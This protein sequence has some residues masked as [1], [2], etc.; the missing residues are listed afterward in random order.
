MTGTG[1][2]GQE[3]REKLYE[4]VRKD[5][6]FDQ[7]AREALELGRRYLGLENGH[8]T[9]IDQV[10]D[11]WEIVASTDP[12]H[13]QFPPGLELG[14]G[15]T[16]CR[17]VVEDKT[18]VALHDAP[19]QGWGDDPAFDAHGLHCYLG[20][21]LI[22]DKEPYGTVCFVSE[23]PHT[24]FSDG[25]TMFAELIAQ[26]LERELEGEIHETRLA[27]QTNLATVLGRVLRHNLRNDLSVIRGYV[28]LMTDELSNDMDGKQV[29]EDIDRLI[30]LAEKAHHLHR[31]VAADFTQESVD[32]TMLIEEVVETV[33][34]K[35]PAASITAESEESVY[36][37]VMAS[38]ERALYELIENAAKHS[39][40][41]PTVSVTVE[42]V[43][44]SVEL[45]IRDDG[46]GIPKQELAVLES[47]SE[48]PLTHGS[49]LGLW[50]VHWTV[51]SHGGTIEGTVTAE[52][53][54]MTVRIPRK[55]TTG[56]ERQL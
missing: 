37:E 27:R 46:P 19:A 53:T 40:G 26:L 5:V 16:Y 42:A 52:G 20:T 29:L 32:I 3:A 38:F 9:R 50:L 7:Q 33:S 8:L 13:G 48:T 30:E 34:E 51:T 44:G 23:N 55:L 47:G 2:T 1:L 45:Q 15:T 21:P 18:Q 35:Y 49:G 36:A 22:V 4:I 10:T 39:G 54:T 28:Q 31:I 41:S 24:E 14:L 11:H 43:P 6:P 12:D 17:R 56:I 25:E